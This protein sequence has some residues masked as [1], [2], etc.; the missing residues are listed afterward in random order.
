MV[1]RKTHLFIDSNQL[2]TNT[3]SDGHRIY[4]ENCTLTLN[5]IPTSLEEQDV[6]QR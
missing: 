4:R 1:M 3:S 6:A 5:T 2:Q